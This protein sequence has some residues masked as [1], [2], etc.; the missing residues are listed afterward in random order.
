MAASE[1]LINFD[2]IETQKENIQSLP[3]GRSAR[4]LASIFSPSPGG[5]LGTP[6]PSDTRNLNDACRQE[7]ETEILS[8]ADSDDPLDVY[9]R[10]VK[11]TLNAYPSA[12]ATPQSQ[13]LPLLERAT[14]AFLTSSHY[15]NDPRYLKLW[16]QYIHLFSDAPRE[17]FAFLARH[18]VGETLALFYEE[19]AA[20]LEGAARWTQAEEV[21][22]LGLDKQARPVERLMRKYN[23]FQTRFAEQPQESDG[24]SSPALPTVRP[25]L[26]AKMDPFASSTPRPADPQAASN[27]SGSGATTSRSARQKLSIFSDADA[28]SMA[29]TSAGGESARGWESIGSLEHRRK[30]NV[31]EPRPWAGET[32]KAGGK[33]GAVPKLMI[34]KDESLQPVSNSEAIPTTN[35][36]HQSETRNPRTGKVERV[37]VN[38]EAVYPNVDDPREEMSFEELR[39]AR[40]GWLQ[41][42]WSKDRHCMPQ[43]V[44]VEE[45]TELPSLC[46]SDPAEDISLVEDMQ[47]VALEEKEDVPVDQPLVDI[48]EDENQH[49]RSKK[50]KVMEVKAETQTIKTN[51]ESPTGPKIKRKN[52]NEPTMTFHTRAATDEIY[53]IFNQPLKSDEK[54][55]SED[56]SAE[57]SEGDDEDDYTSAGE[58][59]GTGVISGTSEFGDEVAEDSTGTGLISGTSEFDEDDERDESVN[60]EVEEDSN[61]VSEWSDFSAG[62]HI[63]QV[64]ANEPQDNYTPVPTPS[65][66]ARKLEAGDHVSVD[67]DSYP[68]EL[69]TPTSPEQA[70][71]R[72][73]FIPIPPEDYVA[74]T[75]PYRD[76]LQSSQNRLPFMTP[77][78]EKT[79]SSMGLPT[80][81][82]PNDYFS[83]KTPSRATNTF[84]TPAIAEID[85]D[86]VLSSP[87]QEIINEALPN[88]K[89]G[90]QSGIKNLTQSKASNSDK[91]SKRNGTAAVARDVPLKGPIINDLQCNPMD[92][93]VRKTILENTHPPLASYEGFFDHRGE[94]NNRTNEIQKFSKAV[95]KMSKNTGDKTSTNLSAPP[96]LQFEGTDRQYTIKRELGKGAFAPVY[97]VDSD[98]VSEDD[99]E[100]DE[101]AVMGK[102]AF[103]IARGALEA[104][105]MEDTPTPWEFHMLRQTHRRLGVSR[106]AE[107]IIRAHEFH[108]FADECYLVLD[109]RDQGTLLDL[110]NLAK[111]DTANNGVM[112]E[113]LATFFAVELLRTLEALHAKGL[114]HG[115]LKADNCLVRFDDVSGPLHTSTSSSTSF[116]S[117]STDRDPWSPRYRPDGSGGWSAKGLT[118]I[119]FGRAI[120][121]RAFSPDATFIADW[122]TSAAD[123]AEMREL[124]PWT[125]QIDYHGAAGVLHSL[126]FG[127]YMDVVVD[128]SEATALPG[129]VGGGGGGGGMGGVAAATGKSYRIGEKLKRYWAV[130]EWAAAFDLLLNPARFVDAEDA[131][132]M[133]LLK[134]L[135]RVR[136]GLERVLATG[137]EKGVGLRGLIRRAEERVGGRRR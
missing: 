106:A 96:V 28:P 64:D 23:E 31:V 35:A 103:S 125:Y 129:V 121:A 47:N 85:V 119:D 88:R 90:T 61:S 49:A 98:R 97:L 93:G 87:F 62:K 105:K 92:E 94:T 66:P 26:A 59:T 109:Y 104:L 41:K 15:K 30:E 124:R 38:L 22:K 128:K 80:V 70:A 137:C 2:L 108:L 52:S 17:T 81:K 43:V 134:G 117:S 18:N 33:V 54:H 114:M 82:D 72:T 78:V 40:R 21:Y 102:G 69:I 19:F 53:D 73:K 68:Q 107:S 13:L 9:D 75:Q 65:G 32:L 120:D 27:L 16:L 126:L 131:A 48:A 4:T 130:D 34:F 6:T 127:R 7:F 37:F 135:R 67:E 77:I 60:E 79:E 42:N 50:L 95:T 76:V 111:T 118:L 63:P 12:Q 55:E 74:P 89:P 1:D 57:E 112:D 91:S 8:I 46:R 39:A 25:A 113:Q 122:P 86:D 20:W 11:W 100:A 58:S 83:F 36:L 132:R 56:E 5:K 45:D 51:L 136:E 10:Y 99:D 133:P 3:G 123:C 116:S 84:G 71:S 101:H 44:T 110:V 14:K 29:S 24:H 115:D